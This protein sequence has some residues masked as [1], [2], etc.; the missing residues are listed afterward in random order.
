MTIRRPPSILRFM[1]VA[2]TLN[3]WFYAVFVVFLAWMLYSRAVGHN[4]GF[5]NYFFLF[6][7][8]LAAGTGLLT[9]A[10]AGEFDL[11]FGAGETRSRVWWTAWGWAWAVPG[12][13]A[14][15]VFS[16]GIERNPPPILRL[17]A[18]LLFTGG[19]AFAIGLIELRYLVGVLWL[20]LRLLLVLA[21]PGLS[22]VTR[23]ERGIDIPSAG[24]L[25]LIAIAA[26]ETLIGSSMPLMHVILG[27]LV[28]LAALAASFVWFLRDDF[29]GKR[30]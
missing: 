16:L 20:L 24:T 9:R 10:R 30:S 18:V 5:A 2:G 23:L 1:L 25:A 14:I 11:L 6:L 12:T 26:P 7:F 13:M 21:P 4:A 17:L 3:R 19:I 28:G 22:A 29:G 15:I 27:A 8:P